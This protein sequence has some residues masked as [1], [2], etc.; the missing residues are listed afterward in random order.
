M[1]TRKR[2]PRLSAPDAYKLFERS[3]PEA[4]DR[5][6]ARFAGDIVAWAGEHFYIAPGRTIDLLPHQ[7]ALL[8]LFT[9]PG[10]DSRRPK[11]LIYSAVKKSGKTAMAA[12]IA[13]H[14]AKTGPPMGEI[15]CAANDLDQATNRVFQAVRQSIELD[16]GAREQ[17]QIREHELRSSNGTFIRALAS[18]Y[19]GEAG[20]NPRLTVWT[21]LWGFEHERARRLFEELTPVPIQ[22]SLR[23][24]ET[25]AGYEGQS[26]LLRDLFDLGKAGRQMS[27]GELA[28]VTGAP[29]GCFVEAPNPDS[30]VP[31]WWNEPASLVMY[32]D[33]GVAARRMPWQ[34]GD[35][36]AQ[37]YAEQEKTLRPSQFR[38]LHLN[39]WAE[40]EEAFIPI[41]W[42]DACEDEIPELD[43]RTSL[44]LG[45][46]GA[47]SGD[48]FAIVG[49][50]RH[51]ARHDDVAVRLWGLWEPPPGGKIDFQEPY[52]ELLEL[53]DRYN[54]VKICYDPFQL[55][56]FMQRLAS[57]V[58][59]SAFDQGA[60][61]NIAD[62]TLFDLIRDR[63][64][65]HCGPAEIRQ[66]LLNANA[67]ITGDSRMRIEKRVERLKV[68]LA[69]AL[70]MASRECLRL[71]L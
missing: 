3:F 53:I 44:V 54:V 8:R 23:V 47:V 16:P 42:W 7:E 49:V 65:G 66:H 25:S 12:L 10:P 27:A 48:S 22:E 28:Q 56:H 41:A 39:E 40:S 33:E 36:G 9:S 34:R 35:E 19:K 20:A 43:S 15:Y 63:R 30:L 4:L 68:D 24:V 2:E 31:I 52:R 51:P 50:T 21:E 32:W 59:A 62:K 38:R 26:D 5:H 70:A 17:W 55:E 45:V 1:K 37:Y 67:R 14:F 11:N 69:V 13:R 61:R 29:L 46:D 57:R 58:W 60:E 64:I 18:D 6:G 71:L